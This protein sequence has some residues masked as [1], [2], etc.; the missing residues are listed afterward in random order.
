MSLFWG[1]SQITKKQHHHNVNGLGSVIK[2]VSACSCRCEA[3]LNL[4]S[5]CAVL[6]II[7]VKGVS[8]VIWRCSLGGGAS[9]HGFRP[10]F[11]Q[12]PESRGRLRLVFLTASTTRQFTKATDY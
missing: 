8:E 10:T 7:P 3:I 12:S 1:G 2:I 5:P 6:L 11:G 9:W 4:P